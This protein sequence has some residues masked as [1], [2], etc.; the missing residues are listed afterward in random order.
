MVLHRRALITGF[1]SL[2]AA[3]AIVRAGALMPV[4][5]VII[6]P[7]GLWRLYNQGVQTDGQIREIAEMLSQANDLLD[8]YYASEEPNA[9][10]A[11]RT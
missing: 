9:L 3:P 2:L 1:A 4:R 11:R 5:R 7:G 8:Y 10:Y 6:P